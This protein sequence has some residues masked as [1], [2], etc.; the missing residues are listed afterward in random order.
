[1]RRTSPH[2][3]S[4]TGQWDLVRGREIMKFSGHSGEIYGMCEANGSL[5]TCSADLQ[6]KRWDLGFGKDLVLVPSQ[7][8][9]PATFPELLVPVVS[10]FIVAFQVISFA[11][12][13]AYPWPDTVLPVRLLANVLVLDL[14]LLTELV[15]DIPAVFFGFWFWFKWALCATLCAIFV[16]LFALDTPTD[17][18][19]VADQGK[20]LLSVINARKDDRD[21]GS[22]A[23]SPD[24]QTFDVNIYLRLGLDLSM[25][26]LAEM[27]RLS[28]S[29]MRQLREEEER[30][31]AQREEWAAQYGGDVAMS[32]PATGPPK[33]LVPEA[34][35]ATRRRNLQLSLGL[36]GDV[37]DAAMDTL[38]GKLAR[39]ER[40][41]YAVLGFMNFMSL[42]ALIPVISINLSVRN[43]ATRQECSLSAHEWCRLATQVYACRYDEAT[44][45]FRWTQDYAETRCYEGW[46]LAACVISVV[47]LLLSVP[48]MILIV[49]TGGEY[50]N[51]PTPPPNSSM[52]RRIYV[53]FTGV[54]TNAASIDLGVVTRV[55]SA[56]RVD[57]LSTSLL[58]VLLVVTAI[59]ASVLP[60]PAFPPFTWLSGIV[61]LSVVTAYLGLMFFVK[62]FRS[63]GMNSLVFVARIHL[64]WTA[65]L[66]LMVLIIDDTTVAWPG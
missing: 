4:C 47:V 57:D 59:A 15:P 34:E 26:D 43:A 50:L 8:Y 64:V 42:I 62:P 31:I 27:Q 39:M 2:G 1:M 18:S 3:L 53:Q 55:P 20:V 19:I 10:I 52:L 44:G 41:K 61:N 25:V 7:E 45:T 60:L 6:A 13:P 40:R 30:L 36:L 54:G 28:D 32:V 56:A 48:V 66:G 38:P 23:F 16:V 29:R 37:A 65:G 17:L 51:L 22:N 35:H 9:R 11:L 5:F 58:R 12:S 21:N 24:E 49:M 63:P 14:D 33:S 46:H